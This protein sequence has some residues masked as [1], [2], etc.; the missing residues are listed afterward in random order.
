MGKG[1]HQYN[2]DVET[3]TVKELEDGLLYMIEKLEEHL[4]ETARWK[5]KTNL[6]HKELLSKLIG[7]VKDYADTE[8]VRLH[9]ENEEHFVNPDGS[10][11]YDRKI[12]GKYKKGRKP[13][14]LEMKKKFITGE[15]Q[16][17][18]NVPRGKD[19]NKPLSQRMSEDDPDFMTPAEFLGQVVNDKELN[20]KERLRAAEAGAPYYDPKLTSVDVHHSEEDKAPFNIF[21][22][23]NNDNRKI[24]NKEVEVR[25]KLIQQEDGTVLPPIQPVLKETL[26]VRQNV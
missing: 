11:D 9:L 20:L 2:G 3:N 12:T 1:H 19:R 15:F 6:Y 25:Q 22:N 13:K 14:T 8:G 18:N 4:P 7:L 17:K 24:I 26:E 5:G 21:L 23:V 16:R 10:K